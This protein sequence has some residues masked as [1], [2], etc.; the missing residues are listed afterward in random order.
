MPDYYYMH[1]AVSNIEL[2]GNSL[3]NGCK[4]YA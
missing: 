1:E 3:Y 2:Q 4:N